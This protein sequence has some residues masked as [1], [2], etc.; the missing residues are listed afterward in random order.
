MEIDRGLGFSG[1]TVFLLEF[2][3]RLGSRIF[4]A[5]RP[6]KLD[7]NDRTKAEENEENGNH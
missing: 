1:K 6:I 5:D 7:D 2:A 3:N 4:Q